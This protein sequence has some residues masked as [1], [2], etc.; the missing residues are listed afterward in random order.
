MPQNTTAAELEAALVAHLAADPALNPLVGDRIC[1]GV[2]TGEP[3]QSAL[4][5]NRISSVRP[6][7]V[8]LA[9]WLKFSRYQIDCYAPR[10]AEALD[11]ADAVIDCL[12]LA[13]QLAAT[14]IQRCL[15]Q[16]DRD[17]GFDD[18]AGLHRILLEFSIWP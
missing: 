18:A 14:P 7:S 10:R 13:E 12:D 1:N 6:R 16:A 8:T 11:I 17:G 9:E 2:R 15:F 4:V 3:K 5:L